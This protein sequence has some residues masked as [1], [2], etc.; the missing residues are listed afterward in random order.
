[1]EWSLS[2]LYQSFND[3]AYQADLEKIKALSVEAQSFAQSQLTN[4][5][6]VVSK[7]EQFL[8]F[9]VSLSTLLIKVIGYANLV[10][11]VDASNEQALYYLNYVQELANE[12]VKP[13]VAFQMFLKEVE[14]L[15]QV[16]AQSPKLQAVA[17][18]LH[19]IKKQANHLLSEKEEVLISKM[20]LSGSTAWSNLQNKISSTLLVDVI[21]DGKVE[22][23]PLPAVRN[24]AYHHDGKVRKAGYEAEL[25]AYK[26]IEE[27]S[28]AALNG[29]KGEVNTLNTMRQYDSPL[30]ETLIQSRMDQST[31]DAMLSAMQKSLPS[32]H[33]YY[34]HKAKLLNHEGGLPFYDLFAPMGASESS[35][36]YDAAMAYITKQ[37]ATFS[38]ALADYADKAYQNK[39]IDYTPRN[40]KRG[41]AF[42]MNIHPIKESRILANFDGSFSNV[43]T[44]AHELG[45]GYHGQQLVDESIIN[46]RYPMPLAE[47]ASI[48]CET[49]VVN[50]ALKEVSDQEKI[51]ILE[52]SISDAGQVI[53]DIYSRFLFESALFEKRSEGV[54]SVN[55]L[56]QMMV[57]SQKQAYGDGLDHDVLHPYMW[58][59]KPHYY[60]A[61]LNFYNF[62]Y[63]FGLLFAKGLYAQYLETSDGFVEQYN[64]LLK[65]TGKN[66][67]KTVAR[68]AGIDVSKPEFFEKS[69]ALIEQD[70]DQFIALTSQ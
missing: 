5:E 26:Q 53:V 45:H 21:L 18:H 17:Y 61:G 14:D 48:F 2:E 37:F 13:S 3:A 47:T 34:K 67:I 60:S 46:S 64:A 30:A 16:I 29:I 68:M 7:C 33:R 1:M 36:T 56:K 20:K 39:W 63:A 62:P 10:S 24:L 41:G 35:M 8:D 6:N 22:T 38:S 25:S 40:Q 42:C 50:A 19:F 32:F 49:I 57:E 15:D 52:A 54:V 23:L 12:F 70:I 9:Q 58:L 11:A 51:A 55:E 69:L 28:A 31:L 44:L 27:S 66:D 4:L 65:A 59:N 43:I